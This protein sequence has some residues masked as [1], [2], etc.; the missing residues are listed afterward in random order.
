MSLSLPPCSV[1]VLDA[2]EFALRA[3]S[4]SRDILG[5]G[6]GWLEGIG[7]GRFLRG[8]TGGGVGRDPER[9]DDWRNGERD[10][11]FVSVVRE[12][13]GEGEREEA[14]GGGW[15]GDDTSSCSPEGIIRG[16]GLFELGGGFLGGGGRDD[17]SQHTLQGGSGDPET[18]VGSDSSISGGGLESIISEGGLE[19]SEGG[20]VS[21]MPEGGLE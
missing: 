17:S 5:R 15:W 2:V 20:P 3:M 4:M 21:I 9:G 13:E 1:T 19:D 7:G 18:S 8:D 10:A 12:W 16:T 14:E 11:D 6:T